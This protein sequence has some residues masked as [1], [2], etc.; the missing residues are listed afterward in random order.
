MTQ[1]HR[2]HDA[3]ARAVRGR[4]HHPAPS[5]GYDAAPRPYGVL[6]TLGDTRRAIVT[7]RNLRARDLSALVADDV[8]EA[9]V[10]DR[11][12]VEQLGPTL[13][14]V[15]FEAGPATMFVA[16]VGDVRASVPETLVLRPAR[17][18]EDFARRKLTYFAD[19]APPSEADLAR[20]MAT[21][22]REVDLA[23]FYLVEVDGDVAAILAAYRGE[24]VTTYLLATDP[25][26]RSRGVGSGALA[27]WVASTS[28]RAHVINALD[29][30][31]P[32]ELYRRL[33]FTDEVYWYRRFV[34]S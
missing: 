3:V 17:D 34:R 26:Q 12:W 13:V 19:G 33:G 2:E 22:E 20:E 6:A 4:Y 11:E 31:R 1:R 16:L 27:A 24:D 32:G 5:L 28:A 29:G 23:D 14:G 10:E 25:S 9:W 21:R 8:T 18:V 7:S 15:G 30:G